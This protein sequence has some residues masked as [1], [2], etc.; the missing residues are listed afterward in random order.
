MVLRALLRQAAFDYVTGEVFSDVLQAYKSAGGDTTDLKPLGLKDCK[1]LLG[2]IVKSG[3]KLR[4]MIDALDECEEPK[5][6]LIALR[7][8]AKDVPGGIE[9]LVSSRYEVHVDEKF[10]TV[11]PID[12]NTSMDE[13]EM[14]TYI[15]TEVQ[16]RETDER[17]LQGEYPELEDE[18][19]EILRKRAGGMYVNPL[20]YG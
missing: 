6:V 2:K 19:I 4:I 16:D 13:I 8:A 3:V 18:L 12:V 17:L 15:A 10:P 5:D 11:V 14:I 20:S 1:D 9:L 7:D